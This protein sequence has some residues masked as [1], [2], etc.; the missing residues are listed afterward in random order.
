MEPLLWS[1]RYIYI[2][3]FQWKWFW[4]QSSVIMFL[5]T[6]LLIF[7]N[8]ED[9]VLLIFE[10]LEPQTEFFFRFEHWAQVT[11]KLT[12]RFFQNPPPPQKGLFL[13]GV[14]FSRLKSWIFELGGQFFFW[15]QNSWD[16]T[17]R[18][19]FTRPFPA[20][21]KILKFQ[22]YRKFLYF[23][24]NF[25]TFFWKMRFSSKFASKTLKMFFLRFFRP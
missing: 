12:G 9:F 24:V 4:F 5:K 8:F 7:I 11:S 13:G 22:K 19:I 1:L 3:L 25:V 14:C 18:P 16:R 6:Y 20:T 23:R 21:K 2:Y 17:F 10:I 15:W